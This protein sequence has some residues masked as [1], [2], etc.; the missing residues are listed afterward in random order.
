MPKYSHFAKLRKKMV[1][2]KATKSKIFRIGSQR[3]GA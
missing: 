1:E 3:K 2:F